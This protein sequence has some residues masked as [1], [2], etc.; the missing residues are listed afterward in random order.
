MA[1]LK[2]Y[3]SFNSDF[4]SSVNLYL[5]L[6]KEDKINSFIPTKSSVNIL[7]Q[8]LEAVVDNKKQATLLLGPYGKG[9]SHLLLILLA[10]LSLDRD[11]KSSAK[12]IS[13]LENKIAE[14][15]DETAKLIVEVWGK[16]RFLPIIISGAQEDLTMPFL[17]GISDALKR[18]NLDDL[19]PDTYYSHAI[20]C[21]NR[22]KKEYPGTYENFENALKEYGQSS[23]SIMKNL[24]NYN[25]DAL[26]L[27]RNLYSGITSGGAFN[28]LIND[29][30]LPVYRSVAEK[31]RE[32]YGYSGIY[33][34]FDEFSKFIEGQDRKAAGNNMK[35]LQDICE[36]A[37]DSKNAQIYITMVA[38]KGIK[39]Y[40]N[41]LS[42]EIINSF[43]GIEGR[44]DEIPFITSTKN[45]YELIKNAI[46]KDNSVFENKKVTKYLQSDSAAKA[47]DLPA[48][49]STFNPVD[50]ESIVLK[51]CY[52]LSPVSAYLLLHV[53]EKVAQN[54]RTLFTF[55]SK[56]EQGSMASY[57]KNHKDP[58]GWVV[59]ADLIYDY[60]KSLFKK[61][62]ANNFVHNEWLNAEYAISQVKD[63]EE[64][65]VL[66]V[67]AL[68]NIVNKP[69]E[70]P[71]SMQTVVLSSG[72]KGAESIVASLEERGIVYKKASDNTY[73]FKTR[74][75]SDARNEIAKRKAVRTGIVNY[76]DMLAEISTIRY[77]LPRKYNYRVSMTRYFT[78]RF[79]QVQEF[80]G[81]GNADVFFASDNLEDGIVLNLYKIDDEDYLSEIEEHV[82]TLE[83]HKIVVLY[84]ETA[85][86]VTEALRDYDAIKDLKSDVKYFAKEEN[87]ILIGELPLIEEEL[88]TEIQGYLERA[89][90]DSGFPWIIRFTS[91]GRITSREI[92]L[93]DVVDDVTEAVYDRTFI[94]NNEL[95]NKKLIST[96][97]IKKAR[98]NIVS[99]LLKNDIE[100]LESYR[101]GTSAESTIYRALFVN[102]GILSDMSSENEKEA[103]FLKEITDFIDSCGNKRACLE[104][105]INVL[106]A[107]PYGI[108]NGVIAPYL[109]YCISKRE[110]DIVVYFSDKEVSMTP[111]N[112]INMTENPADFSLYISLED[113]A[114]EVYLK[115]LAE[116]FQVDAAH[117]RESRI[118]E[119]YVA[120]Q[121][122]F[123]GLPQATK[124]IKKQNKYLGDGGLSASYG[125]IK[126]VLQAVDGNPYEALFIHIPKAFKLKDLNAVA[127]SIDMLFE[128]LSGYYDY[129]RDEIIV[130]TKRVMG[131]DCNQDLRHIL[132]DWYEQQTESAQNGLYSNAINEFMK[133]ASSNSYMD[134]ALLAEK[135]SKII[136]GVYF[137]SWN[138]SSL[139]EYT[140]KLTSLKDEIE[141]IKND[142]KSR[143]ETLIFTS[144]S[145]IRVEQKYDL[146]D[147]G[148]GIILKNIISD[149][150]DDFSD[151]PV[152]DKVAILLE[153]VEKALGQES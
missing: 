83:N 145:G 19:I 89:F 111:E 124:N 104:D 123:R 153:M 48:F 68:I 103:A 118:A 77:I 69:T 51:G 34:I 122:W 146:V 17:I 14:V 50:F 13:N 91:E 117:G 92:K 72:I 44:I 27:F 129:L 128:K 147:E 116:R 149:A 23:K 81:I 59:N 75:T 101:Q 150:L 127:K 29:D 80:L 93:V 38:H 9:K 41:Y 114:K 136:V 54:E 16:G 109:A 133:L 31:L 28:P 110:E 95:I 138:D 105:L 113:A 5:S 97:P 30:V 39:E 119:T 70:L 62:I 90:A 94:I 37:A 46:I 141:S 71:S 106:Q 148:T 45:N 102:N 49:K 3:I 11:N 63:E 107:E 2:D 139:A 134:D 32:N 6:N 151:L 35:M 40:G 130:A 8:Y 99:A 53:S 64:R 21:I 120:M 96:A 33:I 61:S 85:C 56:E 47:F 87:K 108:R 76:S 137:D 88:K 36:L 60:F 58:L 112:I 78:V 15:D 115:K 26:S 42:K 20:A 43:T 125:A 24:K 152:N 18:A 52:P 55:I 142:G 25:N 12:V 100:V 126:D 57:V 74:A 10:I 4:R 7:K 65:K 121:R 143:S 66:K 98:L 135:L 67:I 132:R 144:K 84:S 82:L 131:G 22:W 140:E 79:M 86:D 1:S 73:V